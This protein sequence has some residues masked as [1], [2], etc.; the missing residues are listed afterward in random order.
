MILS[1]LSSGTPTPV[2][3]SWWLPTTGYRDPPSWTVDTWANKTVFLLGTM[4]QLW[5]RIRYDADKGAIGLHRSE[6][7]YLSVQIL[8]HE[9][10]CPITCR[11]LSVVSQDTFEAIG[12][13]NGSIAAAWQMYHTLALVHAICDPCMPAAS[14]SMSQTVSPKATDL[15]RKIVANSATNRAGT[16][17]VN[18]VQLLTMAGQCLVDRETRSIC[19]QTLEDIRQATGWD[20]TESLAML[21]QVWETPST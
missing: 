9:T 13:A 15:A 14:I 5:C 10:A 18:A 2:E 11:P 20:T 1:S 3:T 19:A 4:H 7:Q 6:W 17:W 12:Y 16:A 21:A 8:H